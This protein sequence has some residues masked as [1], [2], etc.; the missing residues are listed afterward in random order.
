MMGLQGFINGM[1]AEPWENQDSQQE[2]VEV[3]SDS[4]MPES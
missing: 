4:E 3:I 2:R 1:L